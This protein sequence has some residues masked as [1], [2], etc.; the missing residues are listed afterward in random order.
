MI[1]V[2]GEAPEALKQ[3]TCHSC[4]A[5]LEYCKWDVNKWSGKDYSGGSAGEEYIN[6]PRC[7]EKVVL[8]S[9]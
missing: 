2:I 7:G 8:R 3:C 5:K 6:C 4:A 1:K 9:W